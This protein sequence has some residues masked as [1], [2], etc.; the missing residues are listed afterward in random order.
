MDTRALH[1]LAT[2]YTAA[3][4][5]QRAASVASFYTEH[6]S[7]TINGGAVS[8]GREAITAAAQGFMSAFPDMVVTMDGVEVDRRDA[9]RAVYRWTLTGTNTGPGGTGN[10]VR[11]SGREEWTLGEDGLI[12][13][14]NGSF[15]QAEYQR[16]LAGGP[17]MPA[18]EVILRRFESP[19]EV[20]QFEK[21]K[22]EL[23][24]IGG[25]TIGRA[26]YQPGWKWSVHVGPVVGA[27]RCTVEHLGLV[28][29][30]HGAAAFDDG[31]VFDLT[32]GTLFYIPPD[33]HDS[34][35][36]GDQPYVSLH[37]LGAA[38]YAR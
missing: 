2:R 29:S 4:C 13:A 26:T 10:A 1:Q 11:I 36:V 32:A 16:Q 7:L 17:S 34:W 23:V 38:H 28:L 30:G 19:D 20:R 15:D 24:T 3:W 8:V 6:G 5:S 37:L 14:S 33:P 9:R 25:T 12:A 27:T 22:L 21:G 35:V 31:R 18:L